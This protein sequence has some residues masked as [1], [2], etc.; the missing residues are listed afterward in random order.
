MALIYIK[1]KLFEEYNDPTYWEIRE[2]E[3]DSL[4][5]IDM[6]DIENDIK[7]YHNIDEFKDSDIRMITSYFSIR[8]KAYYDDKHY[9]LDM[10]IGIKLRIDELYIDKLK[11]EWFLIKVRGVSDDDNYIN[12]AHFYKCDQLDGLEDCLKMISEYEN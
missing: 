4:I 10:I 5:G 2:R 9:Y 7:P 1:Q 3:Y 6:E 8:D 11:D 12:T